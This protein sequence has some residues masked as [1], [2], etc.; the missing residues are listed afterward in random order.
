MSIQRRLSIGLVAAILVIGIILIQLNIW[1]FD[2]GLRSYFEK[3]LQGQAETLS[4]LIDYNDDQLHFDYSRVNPIY[5]QPF[6]GYYFVVEAVDDQVTWRSRSLWDSSLK[7]PPSE[8]LAAELQDG[9]EEQRLLLYRSDFQKFSKQF[10]ITVARDYTPMVASFDY[11][12]YW[13]AVCIACSLLLVVIV[14][15]FIVIKALKPLEQ[16]RNQVIQ[17]QDGLRTSL[18]ERVP[19]ELVPLV[20]QINQLLFHTESQLKRSRNAVGNLGHALKTPLAVLMSIVARKEFDVLP[21][22]RTLIQDQ[23]NSIEQLLSRELGKARMAGDIMPG[24]YFICNVELPL[25]FE[26]LQFIHDNRIVFK[27][28]VPEDLRLPWNREDMLELLGNLLDN[29]CKFCNKQVSLSISRQ[30]DFYRILIE[31]DGPGIE[32]DRY[33]EV[34]SRG[35]RLDE[36]VAGHGLGLG[37]VRDMIESWRGEFSLSRSVL[38]GLQVMVVLPRHNHLSQKA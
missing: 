6:S 11:I 3:D 17:L 9:V 30:A 35:V 24:S 36:Q 14:Q 38:G 23:L 5:N 29:A 1:L 28:Y 15:R 13:G 34:L 19:K 33:D 8:G 20:D 37:I 2:M 12:Q 27:S 16:V 21:Q 10:N 31:D 7:M 4:A 26:T 18:E 25:L 32:P 22:T